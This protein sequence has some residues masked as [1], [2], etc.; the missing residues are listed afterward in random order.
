[1]NALHPTIYRLLLTI[2]LLCPAA[3]QAEVSDPDGIFIEANAHY[4]A[5]EYAEAI[6]LYETLAANG[7]HSAAVHFNLGN[8]YFKTGD[9]GRAIH[10]F[11]KAQVLA[12]G[13]PDIARNL[14]FVRDFKQVPEPAR[15]WWQVWALQLHVDN[16]FWLASGSFWL[17]AFALVIFPLW[18]GLRS[19][20][21]VG[22]AIGSVGLVT[23]LLGLAGYHFMANDIIILPKEIELRA[24]PTT[25]SPGSDI[26]QAGERATIIEDR[27]EYL[28]V[29]LATGER[30]GWLKRGEVG[31][32]W[33]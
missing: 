23:A 13:D 20:R 9:T 22:A 17:L 15:P 3:A 11:S 10:H 16:W 5:E 7:A 21:W 12:P 8:A 33:D 27:G 32:I 24:A 2:I 29:A 31:R 19:L 1:M 18:R 25:A 28:L 4:A 14:R 30:S 6:T 26:A